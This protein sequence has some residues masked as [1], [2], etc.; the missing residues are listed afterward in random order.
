VLVG[1]REIIARKWEGLGK[2]IVIDIA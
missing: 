2:S 1:R